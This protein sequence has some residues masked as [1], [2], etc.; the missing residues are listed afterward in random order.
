MDDVLYALEFTAL[1]L[2]SIMVISNPVSTSAIFVALT[3]RYSED[4][5]RRVARTASIYALGILLFFAITGLLLFQLFGF[6][7]GAF[8]IAGGILLMITA[9]DMIHPVSTK[10]D[11]EEHSD[12]IALIPLAIP[13]ISGPGT[14]V[15]TVVLM[16]EAKEIASSHGILTGSVA[17]LGIFVSILVVV[18]VSF[19]MMIRADDIYDRLQEGGRKVVTKIMGL[20]VMAIAIQFIIN[21]ITDILP[22]LVQIVTDVDLAA[23]TAQCSPA[24]RFF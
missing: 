20:I 24:G 9:L 14:I 2:L 10:A 23:W 17:I 15:T 6:S 1:A 22:G 11:A 8:R 4:K 21:G 5:R 12:E 16:S 18:T 19:V 13:F 7:V 3:N